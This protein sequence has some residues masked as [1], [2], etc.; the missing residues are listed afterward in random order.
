MFIWKKLGSSCLSKRKQVEDRLN[1]KT[2]QMAA[3]D[4]AVESVVD[5]GSGDLAEI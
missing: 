3:E 1:A 4:M 5:E 2:A